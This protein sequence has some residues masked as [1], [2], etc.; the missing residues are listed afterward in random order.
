MCVCVGGGVA[1][2]SDLNG[3][4]SPEKQVLDWGRSKGFMFYAAATPASVSQPACYP[5]VTDGF[6]NGNKSP[7]LETDVSTAYS[8]DVS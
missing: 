1:R 8:I 3:R 5:A 6:H 4:C 7:G 2:C